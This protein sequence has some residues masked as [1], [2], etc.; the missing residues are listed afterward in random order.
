VQFDR[1]AIYVDEDR[2]VRQT[3]TGKGIG[4]LRSTPEHHVD[5]EQLAY[6]KALC[7]P[8]TPDATLIEPGDTVIQLVEHEG[9][10]VPIIWTADEDQ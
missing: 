7:R 9:A 8:S 1:L 4:V 5:P 10:M 2:T 6:Q 3:K